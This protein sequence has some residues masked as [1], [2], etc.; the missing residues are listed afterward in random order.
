MSY[1]FP[2]TDSSDLIESINSEMIE[3]LKE[4]Q[5]DVFDSLFCLVDDEYY[6]TED[7]IRFKKESNNFVATIGVLYYEQ[8]R[9]VLHRLILFYVFDSSG[10]KVDSVAY[11]S[12]DINLPILE[13]IEDIIGGLVIIRLSEIISHFRNKS[14][15][16]IIN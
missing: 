10:N 3:I 6:I 9:D 1:I 2:K 8:K 5:I 13:E 12:L 14:I 15:S 7:A 4:Y 11:Y 16:E